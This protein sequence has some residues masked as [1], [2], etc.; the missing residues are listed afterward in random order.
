MYDFMLYPCPEQPVPP[1]GGAHAHIAD[2]I[3]SPYFTPSLSVLVVSASLLPTKV[4]PFF[5]LPLPNG[6][7]R[8][9]HFG[10]LSVFLNGGTP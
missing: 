6:K 4:L 1:E 2:T 5:N 8:K 10:A 7:I 3:S 9:S